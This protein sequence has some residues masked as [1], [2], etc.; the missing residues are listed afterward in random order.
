MPSNESCAFT[1]TARSGSHTPTPFLRLIAHVADG[2]EGIMQRPHGCA[3]QT[4][5]S[6][7]PSLLWLQLQKSRKLPASSLDARALRYLRLAY[8][9]LLGYREPGGGISYW[10]K[11]EPSIPLTAYALRF[12]GEASEFVEVDP[13]VVA[14]ARG[15]LLQGATPEGA[16]MSKDDKGRLVESSGIYYTAYVL[17]AL[18]R[19]LRFREEKEKEK[20]L[21]AERQAMS[22][23]LLYLEKDTEG[24]FDPYAV[25]LLATAK[26]FMKEDASKEIA[27]LLELQHPENET[28]YWMRNTTRFFMAG[29][30]RDASKRRRWHLRRWPSQSSRAPALRP[31]NVR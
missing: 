27:A 3:E 15:W 1:R 16:W 20:E 24:H 8:A 14:S 30:T 29:V 4:I 17:Q 5:S 7:Y 26:L 11:G 13:L 19:D 21:E 9:K 18:T 23:A 31:W 22:K 12:L 2:I 6:A 28:V 25:A 10:G